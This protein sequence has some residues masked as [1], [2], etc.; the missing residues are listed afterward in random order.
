MEELSTEAVEKRAKAESVTE[1]ENM[2]SRAEDEPHGQG[3]LDELQE[4]LDEAREEIDELSRKSTASQPTASPLDGDPE[5]TDPRY[6]STSETRM[7]P[8]TGI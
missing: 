8:G 5:H 7:K 6:R 2:A 1:G 4:E 3:D